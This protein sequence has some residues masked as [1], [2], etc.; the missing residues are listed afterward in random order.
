[1]PD[2]SGQKLS[3]T[4]SE[5]ERTQFRLN[6]IEERCR[7]LEAIVHELLRGRVPKELADSWIASSEVKDWTPMISQLKGRGS[8]VAGMIDGLPADSAALKWPPKEKVA[9]GD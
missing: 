2:N 1:M 5:A 3:P 6:W 4:A 8:S 7:N 9:G